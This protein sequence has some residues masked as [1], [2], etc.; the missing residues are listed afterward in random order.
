MENIDIKFLKKNGWTEYPKEALA[1]QY[2][3]YKNQYPIALWW[4]EHHEVFFVVDL[5]QENLYQVITGFNPIK[6]EQ[7]YNSLI[8][9]ILQEL[10]NIEIDQNKI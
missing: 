5:K 4:D 8:M 1:P 9:P 2:C 10:K 7:D 6:T 3:F